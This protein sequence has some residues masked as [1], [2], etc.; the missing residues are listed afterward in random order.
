M[1]NNSAFMFHHTFY[2]KPEI[3]LEDAT[4][5]EETQQKLE[6]LKQDY[7]DIISK[8]S[9]GIGVT[10]L[11]EIRIESDPELPPVASKPYP[12]PLKHHKLKILIEAKLTE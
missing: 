1:P 12:L 11:E 4:I 5:S 9:S 10:H 8:H 7:D 2:S 6:T 3:V